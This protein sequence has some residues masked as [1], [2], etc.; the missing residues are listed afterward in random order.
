MCRK[1]RLA[2]FF[3]FLCRRFDY[4]AKLGAAEGRMLHLTN[5]SR[6]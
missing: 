1:D 5:Y 4:P 3:D 2:G 6:G